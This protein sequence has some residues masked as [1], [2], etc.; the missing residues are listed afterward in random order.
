MS[1]TNVWQNIIP[2]CG[3][4]ILI[5]LLLLNSTIF[6]PFL[7]GDYSVICASTYNQMTGIVADDGNCYIRGPWVS[8]EKPYGVKNVKNYTKIYQSLNTN[9]ADH[10]VR[11]YD[12]EDARSI[13]LSSYGGAIVTSQNTVY[14]FDNKQYK[15]PTYFSADAIYAKLWDNKVFVLTTDGVLGYYDISF[16]NKLSVLMKQVKKFVINDLDGSLWILTT[17]GRILAYSSIY[18]IGKAILCVNNAVVFDVL[19]T[20]N[21]RT[22]PNA[23]YSFAYA[24]S[25]GKLYF[26]DGYGIPSSKSLQEIPEAIGQVLDVTTYSGGIVVLDKEK[27]LFVHGRD[28]IGDEFF[29]YKSLATNVTYISSSIDSVSFSTAEN[30]YIY[31]GLLPSSSFITLRDICV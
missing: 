26:Y 4:L 7:K 24:D 8:V 19:C 30:G 10:F 12:K 22:L 23:R 28:L 20:E 14:I 3:I 9:L 16:T 6:V 15:T 21:L 11:I 27:N 5:V 29:Q 18:E 13:T 17:D 2:L 31:C 25:Q 1:K